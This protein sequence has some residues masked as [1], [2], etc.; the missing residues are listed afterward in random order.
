LLHLAKSLGGLLCS[1]QEFN[2]SSQ[3]VIAYSA[4]EIEG[5][6]SWEGDH[7]TINTV[8]EI[9]GLTPG[10]AELTDTQSEVIPRR[11][12]LPAQPRGDFNTGSPRTLCYLSNKSV[13]ISVR[14]EQ[15]CV[16]ACHVVKISA[17]RNQIKL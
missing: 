16:W 17:Q 3:P 12:S 4:L 11:F 1:P 5:L 14:S 9:P 8:V 15:P 7:S 13:G 2:L 6:V 10:F